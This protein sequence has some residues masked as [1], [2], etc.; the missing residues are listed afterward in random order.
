MNTEFNLLPELEQYD[1]TLTSEQKKRLRKYKERLDAVEGYHFESRRA[2]GDDSLELDSSEITIN[3][4]RRFVEK[5]VRFV[6]G[7][8]GFNI[9]VESQEYQNIILPYLNEI[10]DNNNRRTLATSIVKWGSIL[11]DSYIIIEPSRRMIADILEKNNEAKEAKKYRDALSID[12]LL[13]PDF[14]I[15]SI[16]ATNAFPY[17]KLDKQHPLAEMPMFEYKEIREVP[18]EE[19]KKAYSGKS[20]NDRKFLEYA[21]FLEKR[22]KQPKDEKSEEHYFVYKKVYYPNSIEEYAGDKLISKLTLN[23]GLV[24]VVH[25]PN[26]IKSSNTPYGDDDITDIIPLNY[27]LNYKASDISEIIN[28]YQS[29]LTI[30]YGV[31][32]DTVEKGSDRMLTGLPKDAKV[33]NLEMD[34]DLSASLNYM[35]FM[36]DSLL[37]VFGI[38][39]A[40]LTGSDSISNA[41]G[42]ALHMQ[43]EPLME[44]KQEKVTYTDG[45]AKIN[46]YLIYLGI[47]YGRIK[48]LPNGDPKT[49]LVKQPDMFR[50]RVKFP[51]TLPKDD[52]VTIQVGQSKIQAGVGTR[53][54][55]L[56]ELGETDPVA[57][58]QEVEQ[59]RLAML[60][61]KLI[62]ALLTQ[63]VGG[64]GIAGDGDTSNALNSLMTGELGTILGGGL[65]IDG[66]TE[67]N[68]KTG[69]MD[70][71]LVQALTKFSQANAPTS[72]DELRKR[73]L[74]NRTGTKDV[75]RV[76]GQAQP[77]V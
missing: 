77:I 74:E 42:V 64:A 2:Y 69:F 37:E 72:T 1:K 50:T 71:P 40:S 53:E 65:G 30:F 68:F 6:V 58:L 28:Y 24:P 26:K 27:E 36:K 34:S 54:D 25:I 55:L 33:Q 23:Y 44:R 66:K 4:V 73:E 41:S 9:D 31:G 60:R 3:Y 51:N 39:P 8:K 12:E 21:D 13:E 59:D 56:R 32:L 7:D 38:T 76:R 29:P 43:Y 20:L 11:G 45:I 48:G 57:K 5:L 10:W 67:T 75:K 14:I 49:L 16:P 35:E 52:L 22:S 46:T 17:Y 15:K 18:K 63:V 19:L 47:L 61:F 70:D 62:E